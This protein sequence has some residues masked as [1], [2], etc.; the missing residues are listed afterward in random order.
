MVSV[1]KTYLSLMISSNGSLASE[2]TDT[3]QY[4]GFKTTIGSHDFEYY[5]KDRIV[6]PADVLDFINKVQ[7]KLKGMN[8]RFKL[9]TI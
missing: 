9:T 4:L 1:L 8:V 2:I 6:Q 7:D 3:L 5:W